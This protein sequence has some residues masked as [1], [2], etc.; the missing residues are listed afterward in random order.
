[1]EEE[2]YLE[3]L[4]RERLAN[5]RRDPAVYQALRELE[6]RQTSAWRDAMHRLLHAV[7]SLRLSL[8]GELKR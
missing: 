7:S 8:V 6:V 5:A 3:A 1:M 2:L 4:L